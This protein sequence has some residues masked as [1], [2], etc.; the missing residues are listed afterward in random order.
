MAAKATASA[1]SALRSKKLAEATLDRRTSTL[2]QLEEVYSKIEAAASNVE[3]VKVMEASAVALRSLNKQVGGVEGV[4]GI[5]DALRE[6]MDKVDEVSG[7]VNEVG[8]DGVVVD[9]QDVEE[10]FEALENAERERKE[11]KE[12]EEREARER[13]EAD[14]TRRRLEELEKFKN[15]KEKE[16]IKVGDQEARRDGE[17]PEEKKQE[18]STS[19]PEL[20]NSIREL[21]RMSLEEDRTTEPMIES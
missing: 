13:E 4:E 12:K 16:N 5:V 1:R 18:R 2:T 6:E 8:R 7:V 10:E 14:A 9:E 3:V 20:E 21:K 19:E 15:E 11:A 17:L